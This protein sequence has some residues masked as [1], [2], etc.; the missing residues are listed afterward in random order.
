MVVVEKERP[1][2]CYECGALLG[3]AQAEWTQAGMAR[4]R[5]K[6]EALKRAHVC[7]V[8]DTRKPTASVGSR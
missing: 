6:A 4:F 2:V 5:E 3:L 7:G 8:Q 1:I